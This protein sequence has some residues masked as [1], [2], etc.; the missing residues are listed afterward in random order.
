MFL[1]QVGREILIRNSYQSGPP[2][3]SGVYHEH[4]LLPIKLCNELESMM[5]KFWWSA[6]ENEYKI[7]WIS[8]KMMGRPK[9]IGGL[10]FRNLECLNL[11]F[12]AK[13]LWHVMIYPESLV[14][15]IPNKKY[16]RNWDIG[17]TIAKNSSFIM[18]KSI[19]AARKIV[20]NGKRWRIGSR[21]H[22]D[23]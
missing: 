1:S 2:S 14:V 18:W 12:L 15:C 7:H 20:D 8:W 3:Y 16:F 6:K 5:A 4:F 17:A 22:V 21:L 13:Q 10:G 11:A 23:I 19:L 9:F